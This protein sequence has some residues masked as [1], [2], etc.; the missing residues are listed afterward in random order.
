MLT[1]YGILHMVVRLALIL[2]LLR[3]L[4]HVQI[5]WIAVVADSQT[6]PLN[7]CYLSQ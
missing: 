4:L 6:A 3:V 7:S 2:T 5:I 1:A